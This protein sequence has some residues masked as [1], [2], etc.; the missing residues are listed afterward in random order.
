MKQRLKEYFYFSKLERVG[1]IG[2]VLVIVLLMFAKYLLVE[3]YPK[4]QFTQKDTSRI[5]SIIDSLEQNQIAQKK[6][7]ESSISNPAK[8][9]SLAPF[10]PNE[11]NASE[12]KAFGL[13]E[14]QVAALLNY[15]EAIGGFKSKQQFRKV[16]VINDDLHDQ[17]SSFIQLPEE[18]LEDKPAFQKWEKK[19]YEREPRVYSKVN[20]NEADTTAFKSLYG[21]GSFLAKMIVQKREELGGFV[22]KDQLKE[23]YGLTEE[24]LV[25]LDSQFVFKPI[26]VR[27]LS[28]NT[29]TIDELRAH[30][31]LYWKH[32]NAIVKYRE[33][34]GTYKA[35]DEIK[36]IV[37]IDDSLFQKV[38]PYLKL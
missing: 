11:L 9:S 19:K 36:E 32:A 14:K 24:T 7:V 12:W 8:Q 27:Q 18:H 20:I 23:V 16:F 35:L 17:L 13:S 31:Y 1:I 28:I 4:N 6:E 21:I 3:F 15:K 38:K 22:S 26:D 30:P 5:E 34:H 10:N 29:A 25:R 33:Q 2:L 37:L